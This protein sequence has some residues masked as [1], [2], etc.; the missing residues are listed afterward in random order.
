MS[1]AIMEFVGSLLA[2]RARIHQFD[3]AHQTMPAFQRWS[4]FTYLAG[5]VGM[6]VVVLG[7]AA[8]VG[9]L[10]AADRQVPRLP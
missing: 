8:A 5:I 10:E 7:A 6:T 3:L 1:L 9:R 2:M 4:L